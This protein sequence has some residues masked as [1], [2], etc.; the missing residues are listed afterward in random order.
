ME[1]PECAESS[2]QGRIRQDAVYETLSLIVYGT[3]LAIVCL[4]A[5]CFSNISLMIG[6]HGAFARMQLLQ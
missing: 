1:R 2:Q 6:G 3:P 5:F 4:L